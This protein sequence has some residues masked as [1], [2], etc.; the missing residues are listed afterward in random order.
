MHFLR[1]SS[2]RTLAS[3]RALTGVMMPLSSVIYPMNQ[4]ANTTNFSYSASAVSGTST[5][6][7]SA[8]IPDSLNTFV[9][10]A[11]DASTSRSGR[12]MSFVNDVDNI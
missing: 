9:G 2:R 10:N 5:S 8:T 12:R 7:S 4:C 3:S 11:S 1:I 6:I